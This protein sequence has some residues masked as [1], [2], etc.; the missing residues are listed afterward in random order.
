MNP[1]YEVIVNLV[2]GGK[3]SNLII[4]SSESNKMRERVIFYASSQ[5]AFRI[6]ISWNLGK[7]GILFSKQWNSTV[8]LYLPLFCRLLWHFCPTSQLKNGTFPGIMRVIAVGQWMNICDKGSYFH[9]QNI[10]VYGWICNCLLEDDNT[11]M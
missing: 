1:W 2:W 4:L 8:V 7:K 3:H 9:I 10:P 6:S 5:T 11:W